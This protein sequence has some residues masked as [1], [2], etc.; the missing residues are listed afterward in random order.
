MSTGFAYDRG[1]HTIHR[2]LT[3]NYRIDQ[4]NKSNAACGKYANRRNRF[5]PGV[6]LVFCLDHGTCL[7][8]HVMHNHESP[9]T[10]FELFYTR[11]KEPPAVIVYDNA[12]NAQKF[13]LAR[14][15]AFFK[16]TKFVID[17]LHFYFHCRCSPV[18]NPYFHAELDGYNT[19][20]CE[21]Y[22]RGLNGLKNQLIYFNWKT[23]LFHLQA[24]MSLTR[25]PII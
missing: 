12:C 13:F 23:W 14:E 7:G 24:F 9:R 3:G 4:H 19:Q 2:K 16:N 10:L 8:F 21:Q 22:N 18:Y 6:L 1:A 20:L 15:Y 11:W 5:M 17:K 25:A